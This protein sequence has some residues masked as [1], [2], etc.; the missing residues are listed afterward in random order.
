[1]AI[2]FNCIIKIIK[3][4]FVFFIFNDHDN[5]SGTVDLIVDDNNKKKE[6]IKFGPTSRIREG[7]LV[8]FKTNNIFK[9]T[10]NK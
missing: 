2:L 4:M 10:I 7:D 6:S 3:L 1:M 5:V 9:C 8:N